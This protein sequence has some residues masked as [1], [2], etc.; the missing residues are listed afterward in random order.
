[1]TVAEQVARAKN[2]Y[3]KV[4][5][6]GKLA[7]LSESEYMHPTVSGSVVAVN[8]VNAIEHN[9]GV[10]VSSKN[11]FNKDIAANLN[12]WNIEN[13][14][15][16]NL[17]IYVGKGNTVTVSY[18]QDLT[19]GSDCNYAS[20]YTEQKISPT[21][22]Y[23]LYHK[24]VASYIHKA[25]TLTAIED[26]IYLRVHILD[27][28]YLDSFMNYIG[29]DLQVELGTAA[30]AYTPYVDIANENITVSR[31][32]KNL[33]NMDEKFE[34]IITGLYPS[35]NAYA[36]DKTKIN[37][38]EWL[39]DNLTKD[40]SPNVYI[41]F[42]IN[43][44]KNTDYTISLTFSNLNARA[45]TYLGIGLPTTPDT[46]EKGMIISQITDLNYEGRHS[47][48][49]NSGDNEELWIKG[50]LTYSA[51][52]TG[53]NFLKDIQLEEGSSATDYESY[54]EPQ[55]VTANAD[56]TVGGL[57][58]LSPNMTLM[59]DTDG[60][61]I[62]CQYYRDIDTYINNLMIDVATSGGE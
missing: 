57:T 16:R 46:W 1:M 3:D 17:P 62:N 18:Q 50:Y 7:V 21:E 43:V 60:A 36:C 39:F 12:N 4:Y 32:G 15:Y 59:T 41:L 52:E 14:G 40:S 23:W 34:K 51:T 38:N 53:Q 54:I 22:Q 30:T 10:K 25:V 44:K 13:G 19:T 58:S 48:S 11:L 35:G 27:T 26:Y 33:F 5:K 42:P 2:D 9:L 6:A 28:T 8:D 24:T 45:L 56:G 31:Y 49:F 61:V 55:T 47:K 20:V 29:N 37:P